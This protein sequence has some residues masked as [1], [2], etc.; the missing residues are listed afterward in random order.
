MCYFPGL[1]PAASVK[2]RSLAQNVTGIDYSQCDTQSELYY[3]SDC[4]LTCDA[5]Q[6]YAGIASATCSADGNEFV[7]TN[8]CVKSL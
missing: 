4:T 8:N 1:L 2:F 3:E 7:V 6:G 5:A